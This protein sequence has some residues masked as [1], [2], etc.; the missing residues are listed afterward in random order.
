SKFCDMARA[1]SDLPHGSRRSFFRAAMSE[2]RASLSDP[3][4]KIAPLA[5]SLDPPMP[6]PSKA[7]YV[8]IGAGIHG[9]SSAYHLARTL[10]AKKRGAEADIVVLDQGEGG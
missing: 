6:L 7:R 3:A 1:I 10:A 9:L 8:V 2:I 4:R 5:V